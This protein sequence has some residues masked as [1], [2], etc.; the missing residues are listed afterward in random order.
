[1]VYNILV[2][3]YFY[4]FYICILLEGHTFVVSN[5]EGY[6]Y[7]LF[8]IKDPQRE[9]ERRSDFG[10]LQYIILYLNSYDESACSYWTYSKNKSREY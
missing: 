1:M 5:N 2:D 6:Y 9:R 3:H 8:L 10:W 4:R 7:L